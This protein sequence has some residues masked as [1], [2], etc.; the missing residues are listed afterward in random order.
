M[1][2]ACAFI[3]NS[4]HRLGVDPAELILLLPHFLD[5]VS[6]DIEEI[7][8]LPPNVWT[9]L[10]TLRSPPTPLSR[11]QAMQFSD[12][13]DIRFLQQQSSCAHR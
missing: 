8:D 9:I 12:I 3:R 10:L 1:H 5:I 13:V 4:T 6:H 11:W 7:F 2:I